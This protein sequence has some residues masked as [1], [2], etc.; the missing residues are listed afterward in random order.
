VG[1]LT[2]T[3]V[4]SGSKVSL[5]WS[6]YAGD[7]FAY[8]KVVRSTDTTAEWPL[9]ANDT[10]VAAITNVATLSFLDNAPAQTV[11]SYAVYAVA[12]GDSGYEVLAASNVVEVLTPA[13]T[14]APTKKNCNLALTAQLISP[15]ASV[16][17]A[18]P[19]TYSGGYSVKLRWSRYHCANF[20]WYG[21]QVSE[22]GAPVL[23]KGENPN[24]WYTDGINVLSWTTEVQSGHTYYFRV[25]AFT[26]QSQA[27][28]GDVR[29]ACNVGTILGYS[30]VVKVVVP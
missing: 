20:Q 21:V 14:P 13:V 7:D 3:G 24:A 12:S 30:N 9:G 2:L 28:A 8:Y 22:S 1:V 5:K 18:L 4:L 6:A 17:G 10:L 23:R 29:P 11:L 25:Y 19:A 16:D 26:E 27:S 15:S